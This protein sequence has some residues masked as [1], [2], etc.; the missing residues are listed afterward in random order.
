M[1]S[2]PLR[3][4]GSKGVSLKVLGLGLM[5]AVLLGAK[6]EARADERCF[7]PGARLPGR[8]GTVSVPLRH[9]AP[10][11]GR[12]EVYYAVQPAFERWR[13]APD[14]VFFLAGGPGQSAVQVAPVILQSLAQARLTRDIVFIDQRGTGRSAPL[15]C[16]VDAVDQTL[17]V[18][19]F[20][21][22][23]TRCVGQLKHDVREFTTAAFVEDLEAVRKALGYEKVN[24]YGGSYGT[25]VAQAYLRAHPDRVR[26]AVLD[27]VAPMGMRVGLE[28]GAD[29][30]PSLDALFAACADEPACKKSFPELPTRFDELLKALRAEPRRLTLVEPMTGAPLTLEVTADMVAGLV[31]FLL[32]S[33]QTRR[34]VP[35][36]IAE[37]RAGRL[38]TLMRLGLAASAGQQ[39]SMSLGL[40]FSVLCAEDLAGRGPK[41]IGSVERA[42]FVGPAIAEAFLAVCE[43][44][45][46][47]RQPADLRPLVTKVP[48]LLLSGRLDPVTPPARA[49]Q[50]RRHL[51]RAAHVV[52]PEGGHIVGGLGCLPELMA[53]FFE[54]PDPSA[55]DSACVENVERP[56][57]FTSLQGPD[58]EVRK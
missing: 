54:N 2:R 44:W 21:E 10:D 25:R 57:F 48:M 4:G 7:L 36:A 3:S 31:R 14:P 55:L 28:M 45:P 47:P 51:E 16:D 40:L 30:Q 50:L 1:E 41:D 37:A 58:G 5:G 17:E 26:S 46:S 20:V 23:M 13:R 34:L 27:G 6:S 42:S 9:D 19:A 22:A 49:E 38:E 39:G 32:Y 56:A 24:L 12:I 43:K 11:A 15:A 52:V 29:A 18:G 35:V 8:C 53:D 33:P